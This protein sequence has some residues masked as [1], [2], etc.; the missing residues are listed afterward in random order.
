VLV[1][2]NTAVGVQVG[3]R[4]I[5]GVGVGVGRAT[6]AGRVGGGKGLNPMYG[7]VKTTRTSRL[8]PQ[9][10]NKTSSVSR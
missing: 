6:N 5:R 1:G 2:C 3:G 7:L 8:A 9:V 4:L 10:I